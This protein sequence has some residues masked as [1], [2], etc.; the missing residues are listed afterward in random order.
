MFMMKGQLFSISA[1]YKKFQDPIELVRIP[2]AQTTNEFQPRNVGNGAVLG[3]EIEFRKSLRFISPRI[4]DFFFTGNV[5]L[6]HSTI[7]MTDLEFNARK[8]YQ[9]EGETIEN[10]R[11][12]AGQAPYLINLGLSYENP[13]LGLDGGV[14]YNVN[15]PT[16]TV[17]GGG[18]FPDVYSEPFHSLNFN[19]NKEIGKEKRVSLTVSATNILNDLK[20]NFYRGFNA[21]D[22]HYSRLN[23]GTSFSFGFRY[24]FQ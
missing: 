12:M 1:F 7:D 5:T 18:L 8:E 24:K 6:V 17:V 15:G 3:T 13:E 14:F 4:A 10:T 21:Q 16:L 9:R 20:E 23:P 11:A 22:Q 19:L 2:E